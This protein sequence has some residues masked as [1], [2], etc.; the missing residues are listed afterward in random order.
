MLRQPCCTLTDIGVDPPSTLWATQCTLYTAPACLSPSLNC[1]W[2][3]STPQLWHRSNPVLH[4]S[5]T[6]R[7]VYSPYCH[8]L[9][10]LPKEEGHWPTSMLCWHALNKVK[11]QSHPL[12]PVKP[13]NVP[14]NLPDSSMVLHPGYKGPSQLPCTITNSA[15]L[16][17]SDANTLSGLLSSLRITPGPQ[18]SRQANI[19]IEDYT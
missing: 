4:Q 11:S 7:S 15:K 12:K 5:V 17:T 14:F 9:S 8:C 6:V 19:D 2:W 18:S 3:P 16:T 1:H 13:P 10:T